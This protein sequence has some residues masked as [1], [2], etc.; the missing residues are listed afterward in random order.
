M[1]KPL[2]SGRIELKNEH[3][4]CCGQLFPFDM[5]GRAATWCLFWSICMQPTL[6][7]HTADIRKRNKVCLA[8]VN[9]PRQVKQHIISQILNYAN[10]L[11][12]HIGEGFNVLNILK[13][14]RIS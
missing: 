3:K 11:S 1:Y 8:L 9:K 5:S 13:Y 6:F 10:V 4:F 12:S 7:S 2:V 14:I